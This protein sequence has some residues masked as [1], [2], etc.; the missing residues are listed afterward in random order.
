MMNSP[1]G[2]FTKKTYFPTQI[3][4]IE[5]ADAAALN[6]H[7]IDAIY[8]ERDRDMKGISRSNYTELGGW[9]SHNDLHKSA[10][11]KPLVDAIG[12]ATE[13]M[14]ADLGYNSRFQMTI[15]TMWSIINPPG[16]ANRAHVHPGCLWSGVYYIHAPKGAGHIEFIEPRTAHLMNQPRYAPNAPRPKECW[17][18]VRFEPVPG[19]MIIF[20]SWLYHAVDPNMSK[21]EGRKGHRVIISFNLNQTKRPGAP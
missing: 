12:D 3:F 20:P 11:Y 15:G 16:S 21:E 4:Q 17:T 9:H 14:S 19:R 6:T 10:D 13:R 5:L 2:S 7:L 8:A 1:I 18:K